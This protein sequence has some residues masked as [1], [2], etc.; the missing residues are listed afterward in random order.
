MQS[1]DL[2]QEQAAFG[3]GT[4]FAREAYTVECQRSQSQSDFSPYE[5]DIDS[6]VVFAMYLLAITYLDVS[7]ISGLINFRCI[8]LSIGMLRLGMVPS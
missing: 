7:K 2:Q 6:H 5:K 4:W 1:K 8:C 3:I